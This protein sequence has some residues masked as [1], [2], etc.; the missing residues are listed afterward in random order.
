MGQILFLKIMAKIIPNVMKD[1]N[2]YTQ[3]PKSSTPRHTI[4]KFSK[5]KVKE[6]FL[7]AAKKQQL[8]AYK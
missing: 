6:K 8:V 5:D 4:I 2:V 3:N 7:K 1:V